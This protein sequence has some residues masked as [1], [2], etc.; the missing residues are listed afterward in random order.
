L[1][2]AEIW[3]ADMSIK[4]AFKMMF[5]MRMQEDES[6]DHANVQL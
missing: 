2:D 1:R 6:G 3:T 5:G 4:G